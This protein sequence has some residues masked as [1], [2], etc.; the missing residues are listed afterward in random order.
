MYINCVGYRG[1]ICNIDID[2]CIEHEVKCGSRGECKNTP[3]SFSC[4]C[5]EGFCGHYCDL[6]NPCILVSFDFF[7]Y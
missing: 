2:E 3:G 5:K 1:D 6:I 4:L 7:F